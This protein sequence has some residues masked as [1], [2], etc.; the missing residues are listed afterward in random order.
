MDWKKTHSGYQPQKPLEPLQ[1]V[2][3]AKAAEKDEIPIPFA[4]HRGRTPGE[5]TRLRVERRAVDRKGIVLEGEEEE[6][7]PK[8]RAAKADK[9]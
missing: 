7:R 1:E 8:R 2:E 6:E 5:E 4:G 3:E 9:D